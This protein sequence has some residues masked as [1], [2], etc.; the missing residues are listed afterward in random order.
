MADLPK[1]RQPPLTTKQFLRLCR[2]GDSR[3][4]G[5]E[6]DFHAIDRGVIEEGLNLACGGNRLSVAEILVDRMRFDRDVIKRAFVCACTHDALVVAEWLGRTFRLTSDEAFEDDFHTLRVASEFGYGPIFGY[7]VMT[8]GPPV[9]E[10]ERAAAIAA[11]NN[12]LRVLKWLIRHAPT[13]DYADALK[14][15]CEH[16][17][18]DIVKYMVNTLR[19]QRPMLEDAFQHA[20]VHSQWRVGKWLAHS[21]RLCS[22]EQLRLQFGLD[23][24]IMTKVHR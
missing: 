16:G 7:L 12:R 3:R 5:D 23:D 24:E 8:F 9:H 18:L 2:S 13:L 6:T 11:A 17:N 21:G 1:Q 10:V 14:S 4:I 22:E 15:A 19:I 20:R